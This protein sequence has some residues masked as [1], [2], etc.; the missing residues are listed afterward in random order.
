MQGNVKKN[1]DSHSET[2]LLKVWSWITCNAFM[3]QKG[4]MDNQLKT[5]ALGGFG[6]IYLLFLKLEV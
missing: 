2:T 5:P 4:A 1:S 6:E 3:D